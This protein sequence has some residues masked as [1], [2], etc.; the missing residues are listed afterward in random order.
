MAKIQ[1]KTRKDRAVRK[2]RVTTAPTEQ[3]T[4]DTPEKDIQTTDARAPKPPT[5]VEQIADLLRRPQG[6]RIEDLMNATGWQAHSVRGAIA[7]TLKKQLKLP[8]LSEKTTTG[9]IYRIVEPVGADAQ[10]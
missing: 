5:K 8:V 3:P 9:R 10:P 2:T 4:G 6:A 7:G 1:L